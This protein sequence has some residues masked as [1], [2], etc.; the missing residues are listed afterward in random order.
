M[1][2]QNRNKSIEFCKQFK[3]FMVKKIELYL[4][5]DN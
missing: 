1:D 4:I 2:T 5:N 3:I